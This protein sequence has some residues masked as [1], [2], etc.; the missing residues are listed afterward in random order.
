MSLLPLG[1]AL[2]MI[3][4]NFGMEVV[5]PQKTMANVRTKSTVYMWFA[6]SMLPK[7]QRLAL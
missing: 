5:N 4:L 3:F 2:M 6:M 7:K 1:S